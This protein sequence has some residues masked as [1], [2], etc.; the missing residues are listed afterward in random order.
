MITFGH[1]V[2]LD[3][4]YFQQ[5]SCLS[6]AAKKKMWV[7]EIKHYYGAVQ[8]CISFVYLFVCVLYNFIQSHSIIFISTVS[9]MT[10]FFIYCGSKRLSNKVLTMNRVQLPYL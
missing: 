7:S 10:A 4:K 1:S 9:D 2:V 5:I 8:R 3:G 6:K